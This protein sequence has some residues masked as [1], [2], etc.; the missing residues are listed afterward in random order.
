[1]TPR[2]AA[3]IA[4][5]LVAADALAGTE[6][7]LR[8]GRRLQMEVTAY[9]IEGETASGETTRRGIVA[10]DPRVLPLGSQV[11]VEGLGKPHDRVYDV[12]D[13]GREVKGHE[14]DIFMH[15]CAAARKF[16]RRSARVRVLRVG[17]PVESR[18][19]SPIAG[20]AMR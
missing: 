19:E 9:C 3:L 2:I 10:A 1:M 8:R 5:C 4:V 13:T 16:G 7:Q 14:L 20:P 18:R 15:D 12:E 17:E 6:L 11:R